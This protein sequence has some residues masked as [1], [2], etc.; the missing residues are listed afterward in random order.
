MHLRCGPALA[1]SLAAS[2]AASV[3]LA[4]AAAP[5]ATPGSAAPAASAA[6]AP[7]VASQP[8]TPPAP[9]AG[10]EEGRRAASRIG[11]DL[12]G[13][14]DLQLTGDTTTVVELTDGRQAIRFEGNVKL[15]QGDLVVTA[16]VLEGVYREGGAGGFERIEGTGKFE[17]RQGDLEL[18]CEHVVY[19][20]D[21][22]TV[23]CESSESCKSTKWPERPARLVR[24]DGQQI[25]SRVLDYDLCTAQL[26]A[27]CG[28][29]SV[30]RASPDK[31]RPASPPPAGAGPAGPESNQPESA[32]ESR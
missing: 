19:D 32:P 7:D 4:Q 28:V 25:E 31:A 3:C 20:A 15:V 16:D 29:R 9:A 6:A 5:E 27:S 30:F 1:L 2:L 21:A 12:S 10:R 26:K 24:G 23:H 11:L 13:G 22:C 8:A 18:R 17:L 14:S